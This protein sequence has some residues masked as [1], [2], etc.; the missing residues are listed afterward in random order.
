[1]GLA[2]GVAQGDGKTCDT[3]FCRV[4][5]TLKAEGFKQSAT[6]RFVRRG[7]QTSQGVTSS[8]AMALR[9]DANCSAIGIEG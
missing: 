6:G 3:L 5:L 2:Y 7:L 9:Y 8:I 4:A 1:M